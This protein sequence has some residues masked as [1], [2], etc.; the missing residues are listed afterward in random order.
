[1]RYRGTCTSLKEC[2][3][4]KDVM[5]P[6]SLNPSFTTGV[7]SKGLTDSDMSD[8]TIIEGTDVA[9]AAGKGDKEVGERLAESGCSVIGIRWKIGAGEVSLR[10]RERSMLL[11]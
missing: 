9:V 2:H 1:M 4:T 6:V 10:I 3:C 8:G 7:T 5:P 11:G